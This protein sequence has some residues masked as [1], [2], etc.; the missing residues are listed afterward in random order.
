MRIGRAVRWI[1]AIGVGC[2]GAPGAWGESGDAPLARRG[3]LG[4]QVS[5]T[6]DGLVIV[7][8]VADGPAQRAGLS[9][10]DQIVAID[11]GPI[12]MPSPAGYL[13]GRSEGDV[14]V[15][16]VRRGGEERIVEA[17]LM[18]PRTPDLPGAMTEFGEARLPSG[19][20]VRTIRT[21]PFR[22]G[23]RPK[24]A[25]LFIQHT[26]C[27]TIDPEVPP[28]DAWTDLVWSIAQ[29]GYATMRVDK[30]G[31][32]DS[33][34]LDCA[35]LDFRTDVEV[36]KAALASLVADPRVDPTRVFLV[37]TRGG[38]MIAPMVARDFDVAGVCVYGPVVRP[39]FEHLLRT[40]RRQSA[41]W[42]MTPVQVERLLH[43]CAELLAR[44][45]VAGEPVARVI[46]AHPELASV[47]QS[48][49]GERL[50]G[51]T[52]AF[53]Q[54]VNDADLAAAWAMLETNVLALRGEFDRYS[55]AED[56]ELVTR[57]VNGPSGDLAWTATI[58]KTD[59][60]MNPQPGPDYYKAK[61]SSIG[62]GPNE[63]LRET[64]LDWLA[65]ASE[66]ATRRTPARE[67][68]DPAMQA[69]REGGAGSGQPES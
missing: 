15:L 30:P 4:A 56:Q 58:A 18:A 41:D 64:V 22:A 36:F 25:V 3:C 43:G 5:R 23:N 65:Y 34:G 2:V 1:V 35:E 14:V 61:W 27:A 26:D 49:G 7:G 63:A 19:E 62:A 29:A 44:V 12:A 48:L 21:V 66:N 42:E 57:L 50:F 68:P 20:R 28:D 54:Q 53:H 31:V 24:P 16:T 32:G 13:R 52:A 9:V 69:E 55:F 45:V 37:A 46:E 47:A 51:R 60:E 33:D 8:V 6:A 59:P 38:T 40:V 17:E 10:M 67:E 11:G 39:W